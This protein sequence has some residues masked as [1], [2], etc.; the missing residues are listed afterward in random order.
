M[1]MRAC[2][3]TVDWLRYEVD[4]FGAVRH[5]DEFGAYVDSPITGTTAGTPLMTE[6]AAP[7]LAEVKRRDRK[8]TRLNSSHLGISYAVFCLKK[9]IRT[10]TNRARAAARYFQ[11]AQRI[12]LWERIR[13]VN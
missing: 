12:H 8:S 1:G 10:V 13:G 7:I 4:R 5:V 3:L 11:A 2:R 9:K 6:Q